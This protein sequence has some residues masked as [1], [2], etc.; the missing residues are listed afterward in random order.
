MKD[1]RLFAFSDECF[2]VA[3][4]VQR[5]DG[6]KLCATIT[7]LE[8]PVD[9]VKHRQIAKIVLNL[10]GDLTPSAVVDADMADLFDEALDEWHKTAVKELQFSC[11]DVEDVGGDRVPLVVRIEKRSTSVA[12]KVREAGTE[13]EP[14]NRS[15]VVA[16]LSIEGTTDSILHEDAETVEEP[17]YTLRIRGDIGGWIFN[18][19][20]DLELPRLRL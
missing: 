2:L 15:Q 10:P 12:L 20:P 16:E 5:W 8:E 14:R 11:T 13:F 9:Y 19:L 4:I 6:S 3:D 18:P 1:L 7:L 17:S